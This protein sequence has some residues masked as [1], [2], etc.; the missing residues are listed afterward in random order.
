M[1]LV[2]KQQLVRHTNHHFFTREKVRY[3]HYTVRTREICITKLYRSTKGNILLWNF[4]FCVMSRWSTGKVDFWLGPFYDYF[5]IAA[6]PKALFEF[7]KVLFKSRFRRF[8]SQKTWGVARGELRTM[9]CFSRLVVSFNV[10][11]GIVC[12]S[13]L[14]G[15]H[16]IDESYFVLWYFGRGTSWYKAPGL[17]P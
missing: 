10:K 1:F 8:C 17:I 11:V 16:R 12:Q 4:S 13:F 5:P 15:L 2:T 6:C 9:K 7:H 14:L 3:I